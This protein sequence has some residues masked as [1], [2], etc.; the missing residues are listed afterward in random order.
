MATDLVLEQAERLSNNLVDTTFIG[1][2]LN[3]PVMVAAEKQEKY[4]AKKRK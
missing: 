1:E 3:Q 2:S 4:T